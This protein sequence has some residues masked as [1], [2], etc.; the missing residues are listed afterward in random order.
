MTQKQQPATSHLASHL[1]TQLDEYL[2]TTSVSRPLVLLESTD[3]SKGIDSSLQNDS[4]LSKYIELVLTGNKFKEIG[5][6]KDTLVLYR[7][8]SHTVISSDLATLTQSIAHQL[9]YILGVHESWS[10]TVSVCL[11][12]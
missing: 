7:F 6:L 5:D 11:F 12:K 4:I 1:E 2:A 8:C 10:F 3:D 9:S